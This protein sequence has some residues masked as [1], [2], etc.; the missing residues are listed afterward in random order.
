MNGPLNITANSPIDGLEIT[1]SGAGNGLHVTGTTD[2]VG[3][4]TLTGNLDVSGTASATNVS[5][6]DDGVLSLGTS[7]ELT[8]KHHNSGYSHLIN[9]TGH[10]VY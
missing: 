2:L 9:T 7:D 3:N 4:T 8:L 6:P 5:L 10:F 1:Q